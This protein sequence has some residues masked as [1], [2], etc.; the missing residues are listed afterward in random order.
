MMVDAGKRPSLA[1]R[2]WGGW[3]MVALIW[4]LGKLPFRLGWSLSVPLG[5]A[6][7]HLMKRRRR[8]AQRNIE[9]CFPVLSPRQA[10][11][12][13][14][15]HF[16]RLARTL[17][18]T[19][20]CWVMS[21]R[22]FMRKMIV[23]GMDNLLDAEE[24]GRGVLVVTAHL[25]CMEVGARAVAERADGAGFY[26][27]L[28]NE[29]VEWFQNRSR[30]RYAVG[31]I[32]KRDIRSAVRF[33][34]R[35]GILWYAPDQDFG[36]GQSLFV[37]YFG[38]QTAT[39]AATHKLLQLTGCRVVPM[40]PMFDPVAKRYVVRLQ[41]ALQNFPTGDTHADLARLNATMEEHVRLAP[42]QYWWIHRRFKTRPEGEPAFY[43]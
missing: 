13:V 11:R 16:V 18:E 40:F 7:Y 32:S 43:D 2:N 30:R 4:L 8:V 3:M 24:D 20:W 6:L 14:R 5:W 33:L 38:I 37:P 35:G 25:T 23:E 28:K 29:V 27:P 22:R 9:R 19:A 10:D 42:E 26:R 36:P 17:F 15:G 41:P 21:K 1:P 31:M 34:K 39:L 12:L